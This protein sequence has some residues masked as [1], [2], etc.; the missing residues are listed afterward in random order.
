[1]SSAELSV[2]DDQ[3]HTAL[4]KSVAEN[5]L[6]CIQAILEIR[7]SDV[8]LVDLNGRSALH[9]ACA[10][11]T[12]EAV[13]LLLASRY[14]DIDM[15]DSSMT[16]PLHLAVQNRRNDVVEVLLQRCANVMVNDAAKKTPLDY[17]LEQVAIN[18]AVVHA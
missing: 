10:N 1:L 4:H 9:L 17:A 12:I 11:G 7:P 18:S 13:S 2:S 8:N 14:C 16:S 15:R 6:T 5:A 3:G